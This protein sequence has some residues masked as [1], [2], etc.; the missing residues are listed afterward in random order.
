MTP[1]LIPGAPLTAS[2]SGV[3]HHA[4]IPPAQGG[5]S[6]VAVTMWEL[7]AESFSDLHQHVELNLVLD[8]ELHVTSGGETVVAGPG[9]L[10]EVPAG[11]PGT[12][13]APVYARMLAIYGPNP[14]GV[15]GQVIGHHPLQPPASGRPSG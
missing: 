5:W 6:D 10:V 14:S 7:R 9:D 8:G 15:P 3:R 2:R 13:V 1:R 11:A 12:Y 4:Y